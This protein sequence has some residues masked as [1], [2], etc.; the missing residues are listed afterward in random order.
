MGTITEKIADGIYLID[1]GYLNRKKYAASYIIL[2]N[3]EA[4]II[5]T[6]TNHAIPRILEG[7]EQLNIRREQVKLLILTH[8]HLDHAGGAGLLI[9]ELPNAKL[10]LHS[11]GSRHMVSPEKLIESVKNVYGENKYKEMYGDILPIEKNRIHSVQSIETLNLGDR[12]LFLFETLGHAKH[13]ISIFDKKTKTI[14]SG[15]AFGIGYPDF[16]F[17]SEHILFPSSSPTQFDPE[18]AIDSINRIVKLKPENICLTHFGSIK[19]ISSAADQLKDWIEFIV[20]KGNELYSSGLRYK[21]LSDNLEKIIYE[22][23]ESIIK[24]HREC[25][26][27]EEE[28]KLLEIDFTLN[29]QGAALY[30]EHNQK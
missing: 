4:A 21:V 5:E 9:R 18:S 1:T 23:F 3:N 11:R 6:N 10:V 24:K 8:I 16:T 7:L 17:G 12:E 29:A 26:L 30:I 2:E 28:R 14:F 19:N 22:R 20:K 13:H 27:T 15:D 25:N